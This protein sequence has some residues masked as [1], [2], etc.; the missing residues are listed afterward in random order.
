MMSLPKLIQ[1]QM[2]REWCIQMRQKKSW[3]NSLVFFGMVMVFFPLTLPVDPQLH[4]T[5]A[6]GVV[7]I[8]VL[9]SNLL[10]AERLFQADY[11]EGVLE[12]WLVSGQPLSVFVLAK[13]VVHWGL[14][15]LPL[16]GLSPV[17]AMLFG[18][19]AREVVVLGL[20]L[21]VGT[22]VIML[23][24]A[25]AAAFGT[26]LKQKGVLMGLV[27]LPLTVPIMILGTATTTA[28]MAGLPVLGYFAYLM[29]LSCL[30]MVAL[31]F[32]TAAVLRDG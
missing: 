20:S 15:L 6:P 1:Q 28:V 26:T 10:S 14:N 3:A 32:V 13:V 27:L 8:A 4:R 2:R 11:D 18:L 17:I 19:D 9:L 7:W 24:S 30:A 12:L 23:L 21:V 31:P 5:I 29:G 22:P 16:L 25:F